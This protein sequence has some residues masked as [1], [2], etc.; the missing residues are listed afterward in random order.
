MFGILIFTHAFLGA[1]AILSGLVAI[2][3]KKGSKN[4]KS[5]GKT[6]FYCMLFSAIA[7]FI[8]SVLPGHENPFLFGIGIFSTYFLIGGYRSLK[9]KEDELNLIRDKILAII[10]ILTGIGMI[11]YPIISQGV[12]NIVL[13][14]FGIASIAFGIQDLRLFNNS[15]KV[16][17]GWLASH[18]GKMMGAYI[19]ATTAFFVVNNILP[20]F[21]N[22]FAPSLPGTIY[23]IYWIRKIKVK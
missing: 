2:I 18:L 11:L 4:H 6:F 12:L 15:Q 1:L 21:F 16:K 14:V 19:S 17:E 13:T 3:V 5:A 23:I 7:A 10:I 9:Y 22:W 20:G 8:I